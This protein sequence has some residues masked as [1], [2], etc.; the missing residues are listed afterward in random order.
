MLCHTIPGGLDGAV[1]ITTIEEESDSV[2][3]PADISGEALCGPEDHFS[4]FAQAVRIDQNLHL[5]LGQA[6]ILRVTRPRHLKPV[7]SI[8]SLAMAMTDPGNLSLRR[9][10][11][12][13]PPDNLSEYLL[14]FLNSAQATQGRSVRETQPHLK[15]K[16]LQSGQNQPQRAIVIGTSMS[17]IEQEVN[18]SFHNLR[19]IRPNFI[20][21]RHRFFRQGN[22]KS[23]CNQHDHF[24]GCVQ[25][26]RLSQ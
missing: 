16:T 6:G 19:I 2:L 10:I 4:T 12:R 20:P 25:T 17:V 23:P 26:A 3:A 13:M 21:T 24:L 9:S 1:G 7:E 22:A 5:R 15:W 8:V 11:V 18:V 14:C